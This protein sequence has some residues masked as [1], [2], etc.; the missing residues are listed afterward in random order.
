MTETTSPAT[1]VIAGRYLAVWSEP[2][3]AAR[4]A[5]VAELWAADGTEFVDGGTQHHGLDELAGMVAEAHE[6]FV[7]SG[8]FTVT[9]TSDVT[10]HD[11]IVT[12]TIQLTAPDG[13]VGWAARVFLLPGVDGLIRESYRLTVQPLAA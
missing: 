13:L 7:A 3:A 5:A 9:G 4:R 8:R 2:D 11:D 1:A 10:R 12:F 6:A